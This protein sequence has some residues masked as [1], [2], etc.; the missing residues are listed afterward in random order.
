M[1][2]AIVSKIDTYGVEI[3]VRDGVHVVTFG[4]SPDDEPSILA[5]ESDGI[6]FY[7]PKVPNLSKLNRND[8]KKI[9]R[10]RELDVVAG[11]LWLALQAEAKTDPT[12]YLTRYEAYLYQKTAALH[13]LRQVMAKEMSPLDEDRLITD[14]AEELAR[15]VPPALEDHPWGR[16]G[17]HRSGWAVQMKLRAV[18]VSTGQIL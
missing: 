10:E 16:V 9:V 8:V 5:Y 3:K 13:A 11:D 15:I 17:A 6:V 4:A 2:K 1:A 12:L 18:Y 7:N 14:A